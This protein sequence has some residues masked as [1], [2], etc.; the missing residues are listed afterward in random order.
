MKVEGKVAWVSGAA[1][2]IGLAVCESLVGSGARVMMVDVCDAAKGEEALRRVA[3]AG[4][5]EAAFMKGD[6]TMIG[7]MKRTLLAAKT[8][9]GEFPSVVI[10]NAGIVVADKDPRVQR[11]MDLNATGV[12]LGTILTADLMKEHGVKGVIINT[13]SMAGLGPVIATPAYAASKWAVVGMT[14][15]CAGLVES[16]GVRVNCVCPNL[17]QT[18]AVGEF[19]KGVFMKGGEFMQ[20][21]AKAPLKPGH[22]SQAMMK[23][24]D[25]DDLVGQAVC[26]MPG[27]TFINDFKVAERFGSFLSEKDYVKQSRL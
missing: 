11:M 20:R 27:K 3:A 8:R 26:V 6:M 14:V 2:G 18:P 16:H 7:D 13:A 15:S 9:F 23:I 12:V 4:K 24:I 1:Q 10:H 25:D 5:G 17:V 22:I 19:F 21:M